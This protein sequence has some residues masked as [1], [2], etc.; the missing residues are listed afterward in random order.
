M[1]VLHPI[2]ILLIAEDYPIIHDRFTYGLTSDLI[3]VAT[4][5]CQMKSYGSIIAIL[6]DID[7]EVP[8]TNLRNGKRKHIKIKDLNLLFKL[9]FPKMPDGIPFYKT[10]CVIFATETHYIVGVC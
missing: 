10:S 6:T 8:E 2:E 4:K 5:I 1:T 7:L 3:T 9:V